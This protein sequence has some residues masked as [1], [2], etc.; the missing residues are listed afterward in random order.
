[1][2]ESGIYASVTELA[3]AEKINQSYLCRVL[4]LTLLAP[5]IV[6]AVLDGGQGTSPQLQDLMKPFPLD[7]NAQGNCLI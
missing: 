1:M 7:W 5:T 2:M 3:T 6:E 4:R